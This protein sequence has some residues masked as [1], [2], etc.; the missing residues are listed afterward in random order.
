MT[1]P[2]APSASLPPCDCQQNLFDCRA[3]V[4]S[5]LAGEG[6][7]ASVLISR[8]QGVVRGMAR[9]GMSRAD[10]ATIDDATQAIWLKL[11]ATG[12]NRQ[13]R[14]QE[15]LSRTDRPPFCA[16]LRYL[17]A[18]RLIDIGRQR[19][20]KA[21]IQMEDDGELPDRAAADD[22]ASTRNEHSEQLR[23]WVSRLRDND[24]QQLFTL[25]YIEELS[26]SECCARL[27]VSE[28]TY[29]GWKK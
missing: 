7:S 24:L 9:R 22:D 6:E 13:R 17:A 26:P 20:K 28:R 18:N 12:K 3:Q 23:Q 10:E 25:A 8:F 1:P 21:D 4:Q 15:W 27:K 19:S 16:W 14:L 11:F 29:F 2:A 5:Y